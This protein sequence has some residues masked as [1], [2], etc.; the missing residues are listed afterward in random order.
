MNRHGEA[1]GIAYL[2]I[3]MRQDLIAD[4]AG[5]AAWAA[6]LAPIIAATFSQIDG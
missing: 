6:R 1:N 5:V 3:E 4:E 2:G